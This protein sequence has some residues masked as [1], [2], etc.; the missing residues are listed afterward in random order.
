MWSSSGVYLRSNT[1][2]IYIN[3]LPISELVSDGRLFAD[4]TN[5]TFADSNADKLISVL[6]PRLHEQILFDKFHM[7]KIFCSCR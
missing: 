7:S 5:L 6:K 1:V 2:L 3:D 4:D